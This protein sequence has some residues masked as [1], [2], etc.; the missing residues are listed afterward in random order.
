VKPQA[1]PI[2]VVSLARAADR[3]AAMTRHLTDLGLA[4]EITDAVDGRALDQAERDRMMDPALPL[5]PGDIG[6][7]LSHMNIYERMIERDIR[8]ALVMEDD[9]ALNP[10]FAPVLRDGIGGEP[11]FD[12]CFVDS[13]FVGL[14]G[15]I[16]Y[17]PEDRLA[18]G[19]GFTAFRFAP[20]PHGTQAYL[21]TQAMA[22]HR[23]GVRLPITQSID[24]Y[25][26]MPPETRYYGLLEPRGAWLNETFSTISY[27]SPK[28]T[29]NAQ[30]WH[31]QWR[32][33]APWY[34]FW[35]LVHPSM[36]KARGDVP[37]LVA[38]GL[39][40]AG[41]RWRPIP[42]SVAGGGPLRPRAATRR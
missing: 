26:H 3:R 1:I 5:S 13:W 30:P 37:R 38:E 32:R 31:M 8:L 14:K 34:D 28:K 15:R 23:V 33:F 40:P 4:F 9:A 35:N 36:I 41:P 39:L 7:Y 24:W 16:F 22:R 29:R 18:L 27:V 11:G 21:I 19:H 10:A 25:E 20:P 17:D 2:F 42:P 6:C 12:F